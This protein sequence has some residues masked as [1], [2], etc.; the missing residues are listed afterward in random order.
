M[1]TLPQ[2]SK[3]RP[4]G[5]ITQVRD[6]WFTIMNLANHLGIS[7]SNISAAIKDNF[8]KYK[9]K[10]F[11]VVVDSLTGITFVQYLPDLE[12]QLTEVPTTSTVTTLEMGNFIVGTLQENLVLKQKLA[13]KEEE[14]SVLQEKFTTKIG[15]IK[16]EVVAIS[17]KSVSKPQ[18]KQRKKSIIDP[19][20]NLQNGELE[21]KSYTKQELTEMYRISSSTLRKWLNSRSELM[22]ELEKTGYQITNKLFSPIQVRIIFKYLGDPRKNNSVLEM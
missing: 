7:Q 15:E 1:E 9:G 5:N 10:S 20:L 22:L 6:G 18:R 17:E 19:T 8:F 14:I 4:V 3:N 12:N 2:N 16:S 11:P 13:E 21:I